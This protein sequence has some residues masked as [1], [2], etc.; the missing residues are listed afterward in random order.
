M[1][2]VQYIKYD[3]HIIYRIRNNKKYLSWNDFYSLIQT[4]NSKYISVAMA[5]CDILG[6]N[7]F[8]S[9]Y[10][11]FSP[12]TYNLMF[13]TIF[14]FVLVKTTDF[15]NKTD[16]YSFGESN[17]N[18][19]S[20]AIYSFYNLSKTS[21]LISPC[22]NHNYNI[23]IYNNIGT[24]M[25]STNLEQKLLLLTTSFINYFNELLKNPDKKQWLSTHGKGIG[26]LHMRI[27]NTAR[28]ISWKPYKNKQS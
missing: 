3:D 6:T 21:I 18:T 26:W 23:N 7:L 1:E 4:D 24:F 5:I 9:Y 16:I 15:F 27:D 14:E 2:L 20:N 12:T 19:N 11:E 17:L 13:N 28:Y 25:R 10:L 8:I 22:Y